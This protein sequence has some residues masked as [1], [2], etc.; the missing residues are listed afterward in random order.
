MTISQFP[1]PAGGVPTGTTAQR[2]SNPSIGDVFYNGSLGILEIFTSDGW[3][4]CSAAPDKP[5]I[6][7]TDASSADAYSASG[8]KLQ[9]VFT[10]GSYG[11]FPSQYTAFT[12]S[13][14]FSSSSST[15]TV[16]ISGLTPGTA[17]TV[18]GTVYNGLGTSPNSDNSAAT[19]PSTKPQAPTI[20]TATL[21][22][23]AVNVTW[24]LGSNGGKNLTA[25]NVIPY[26]NGTT[27]Q[28]ATSVSTSA[29]S[30]TITGLTVGSSY[31][32]KVKATNANGDSPES[33]A[34]GSV[35]IPDT[36]SVDYLVVGGGG[37]AG[38]GNNLNEGCGGGGAGGF[39]TGT[40]TV[41]P[42]PTTYTVT[43]GAGSAGA[44][45]DTTASAGSNSV[46]STFTANG[47]GGGSSASTGTGTTGGSGGGASRGP[48]TGAN[49]TAGQGNKGGNSAAAADGGGGGGASAAGSN[50][51][52]TGNG[53]AGGNGTASSITGTSV[54]YAGGGGG[55]GTSTQGAGGSGGGGAGGRSGGPNNGTPGTANTGGGGGALA[56]ST[57]TCTGGSG[58]SGVVI[59]K[60]PSSKTIT[61]GAGLTS[62]ESTSG[63]FKIRTFTAGTGTVSW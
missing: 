40:L 16:T 8:G 17:Y 18:Y 35:T 57:G 36:F 33:G 46:F 23:Q 51:T 19:T 28:T 25:L 12:T 62:T 14:G 5:T 13:G 26:L 58:G 29:S 4:T 37:G 54:T 53:G 38:G 11:G 21:N 20:G 9:V 22:G 39:L 61:V 50:G 43:V 63:G 3:K 15:S 42:S 60:Y 52:A 1:I 7:V 56:A 44:A 47:G 27:A 41:S 49:G 59:I 2:P 55:A 30:A 10:A 24:T 31:T 48:S 34:T 45:N 6:A 32:F